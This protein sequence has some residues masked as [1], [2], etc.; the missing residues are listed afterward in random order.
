MRW[1]I[2]CSVTKW[3]SHIHFLIRIVSVSPTYYAMTNNDHLTQSNE[4]PVGIPAVT[5]SPHSLEPHIAS[6][7]VTRQGN[8]PSRVGAI[9]VVRTIGVSHVIIRYRELEV[10]ETEITWA[11][12]KYTGN[13][14]HQILGN[15]KE[16]RN[17]RNGC[18]KDIALFEMLFCSVLPHTYACIIKL[19]RDATLI[20]TNVNYHYYSPVSFIYCSL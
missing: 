17:V 5:A 3:K 13:N 15:G 20:N 7:C 4:T 8:V 1:P 16:S 12:D 10:V 11:W 14:R 9:V 19:I 2:F 18:C 6:C